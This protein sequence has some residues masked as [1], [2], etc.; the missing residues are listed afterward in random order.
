M[1][2][3]L[4]RPRSVK[5]NHVD[6]VTQPRLDAAHVGADDPAYAE[7][8]HRERAEHRAVQHATPKHIVPTVAGTRAGPEQGAGESGPG[9][10]GLA[11][12]PQWM[13]RTER[14]PVPGEQ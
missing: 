9:P 14:D 5:G 3:T 13:R 1:V 4:F 10:G 11:H 12:R 6:K 8:L 7:I 2:A